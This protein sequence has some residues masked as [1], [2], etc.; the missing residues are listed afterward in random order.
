MGGSFGTLWVA[1]IV[2]LGSRE[3]H[4]NDMLRRGTFRAP[5]FH[6]RNGPESSRG[7]LLERGGRVSI[8]QYHLL[9]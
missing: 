7:G 6:S 5:D 3:S 4:P 2:N 8:A 1:D 9:E